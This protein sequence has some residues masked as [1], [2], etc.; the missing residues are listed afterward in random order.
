MKKTILVVD[1]QPGICMLLTDILTEEGYHVET[2]STGKEGLEKMN[3]SVYHLVLM[4][5]QLPIFNAFEVV[6]QLEKPNNQ[7][8]VI[9]MTGMTEGIVREKEDCNNI[10]TILSKP[11]NI[12]EVCELVHSILK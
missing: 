12:K 1:D 7:I 11:F 8:P 4:D 6:K 2:A 9:V 5:Y 3:T 10:V